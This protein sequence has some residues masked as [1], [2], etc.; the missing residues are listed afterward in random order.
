MTIAAAR[1]RLDT[2]PARIPPSLA[3]MDVDAVA[4]SPCPRPLMP[5]EQFS[6][7]CLTIGL[8]AA[9]PRRGLR[10]PEAWLPLHGAARTACPQAS[11]SLTWPRP[12]SSRRRPP[13]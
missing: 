9:R 12:K 3:A 6:R 1:P 8:D 2:G 4:Q 11:P 5:L 13:S 7:P 10:L